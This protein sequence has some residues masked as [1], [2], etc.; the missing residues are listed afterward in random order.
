MTNGI[1]KRFFLVL[2]VI[3]IVLTA[4]SCYTI[5][6]HPT[7][8]EEDYEM[9]SD[10]RCT[11]CH[12][13]DEIWGFHH[14]GTRY[15]DPVFPGYRDIL[16]VPWWYDDYWFY[17]DFDDTESVPIYRRSLRP[18]QDKGVNQGIRTGTFRPKLQ[19]EKSESSENVEKEDTESSTKSESETRSVRPTRKKKKKDG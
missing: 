14:P 18:E 2:A 19:K 11:T 16:D 6:R 17:T 3:A 10:D 4:C 7:I 8:I 13:E 1:H 12:T 9:P 5:L 15:W